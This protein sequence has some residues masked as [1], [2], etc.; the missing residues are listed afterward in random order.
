MVYALFEK[1]EARDKATEGIKK[2]LEETAD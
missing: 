1:Y 2:F